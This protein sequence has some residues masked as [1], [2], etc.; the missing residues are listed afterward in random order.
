[1]MKDKGKIMILI[2]F[3]LVVP[4]CDRA[5]MIAKQKPPTPQALIERGWTLERQEKFV[6]ALEDYNKAV[7][8]DPTS[9][10]AYKHRG[11][12]LTRMGA[13]EEALPDFVQAIALNPSHASTYYNRAT[14]Y[15]HL[16]NFKQAIA[17]YSQAIALEPKYVAAILNRAAAYEST[18]ENQSAVDDYTQTLQI[19]PNH[20]AALMAR[21]DLY[22][23]MNK[24]D[25]SLKDLSAL[26]E[27]D[28]KN[29]AMYFNRGSVY[30]QK[31][32][33]DKAVEDYS[34]GIELS[35]AV[36][37]EVYAQR[38]FLYEQI[39]N[40]E[41]A[42]TDLEKVQELDPAFYKMMIAQKASLL[43]ANKQP[44]RAIEY[45]TTL[46][47]FDPNDVEGYYQRGLVYAYQG[48]TNLALADYT[49]ALQHK[50]DNVKIYNNRGAIYAQ[51]G[52]DDLALADFSK[53][54]ELN[55]SYPNSYFNRAGVYL[56]KK[57]YEKSWADVRKLRELGVEVSSDFI[58]KLEEIS[59]E[60]DPALISVAA[61][62]LSPAIPGLDEALKRVQEEPGNYENHLAVANLYNSQGKG[63][64]AVTY[65]QNAIEIDGENARKKGAYN[66][67]MMAYYYS[68]NIKK[69]Y[70]T[71]EN[72]LAG[73]PEN[74]DAKAFK[75][76]LDFAVKNYFKGRMPEKV[77]FGGHSTVY[78]F[79]QAMGKSAQ[80]SLGAEGE[81]DS[82][83]F[84]F[85]TISASAPPGWYKRANVQFSPETKSFLLYTKSK[86]NLLPAI[87]VTKDQAPQGTKSA[88]DFTV[89]V[90]GFLQQMY[91]DMQTIQMRGETINGHEA[92]YIE[93][94]LHGLDKV[95]QH[96]AW[97]QFLIDGTIVSFQYTNTEYQ[98]AA[99]LSAFE[100]VVKSLIIDKGAKK[101]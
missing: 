43:F 33:Y 49:S 14:L 75:E 79:A 23:R 74:P 84:E 6:E 97:Y 89:M 31:G 63:T 1:M 65:A 88:Q 29:G 26:I 90:K 98:F 95:K 70:E 3:L 66:T 59:E 56:H 42:Q 19:Q 10:L 78:D 51:R 28:P 40:P 9:F 64:E 73:D 22:I 52:E 94:S 55:P 99:D 38:S 69:S 93:F 44:D 62:N 83:N 86:D 34:K 25:E 68:G 50:P 8:M 18:G 37:K 48:K 58:K 36:G 12:V 13:Y 7:D 47:G 101:R 41:K 45:Y 30:T 54:I 16:Q 32:A 17:D 81:S 100:A 35:L 92:S 96:Q 4:A 80:G 67:L 76:T 39:G 20:A 15:L 46:L 72:I 2:S 91:P 53:A 87:A 82:V 24:I 85:G 60:K 11:M 57:E 27:L 77:N 61:E 71:V 21:A 5:D